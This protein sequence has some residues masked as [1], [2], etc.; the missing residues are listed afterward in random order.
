M[1]SYTKISLEEANQIA[2]FYELGSFTQLSPL[3][4]GISNSN[5][6]VDAQN[7]SYLL[8]ISNDKGREQLQK[9]QEILAYLEKVEFE[10]SICPIPTKTGELIYQHSD[11]YG[12]IYPFIAGIPPGPSDWTCRQI[13][14]GLASLHSIKHKSEGLESLRHHTEVGF[15]AGQIIQYL[16]SPS[17]PKEYTRFFGIVFPDNLAEL[18]KETFSEGIIHG[19]LYYDNT[20]FDNNNLAVILDFEQAGRGSLLLDLGISIS[21]TCLEK[22][23]LIKPL[24]E[25]FLEGY[26]SIKPLSEG[27]KKFIDQ[28]ILVGLF[29]IALWRIKRFTEGN[30]N[31]LMA[32]SYLELLYRA[33][34]FKNSLQEIS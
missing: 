26:E 10:Y 29:S 7:K 12:V 19:D 11:N 32:D 5:Y 24:I 16:D 6:R 25:S 15:N 2:G 34:H 27:E 17:C 1:G 8:K 13:G 21:G 20:L 4:L 9:E 3:S 33:Q 31:H 28:A 14:E 30:L 18:K 23:R 22:G